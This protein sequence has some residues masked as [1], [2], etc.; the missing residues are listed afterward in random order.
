MK[1]VMVIVAMFA[2]AAV[3]FVQARPHHRHGPSKDMRTAYDIMGLVE[4]GC[5]ILG[6]GN[7]ATYVVPAA[8]A[9]PVVVT[10]PAPVVVTPPPPA[11]VVVQ[12][13]VP[14]PVI[15]TGPNYVKPWG[16]RGGGHHAPPPPRGG[17][18]GG[19]HRGGRR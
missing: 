11:P 10:Q 14:Q 17:H 7:T 16:P 13:V 5:R 12:P 18:R 4:W 2:F 3:P 8:P 15:I 6:I 9:T 1:K 19:R